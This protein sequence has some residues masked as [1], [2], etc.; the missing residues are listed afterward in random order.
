MYI[1][2]YLV[3][4]TKKNPFNGDYCNCNNNLLY[5]LK[6]T[7]HIINMYNVYIKK[8]TINYSNWTIFSY[9]KSLFYINF[10]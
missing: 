5:E 1:I 2:H 6:C 10:S 4:S 3:L 7:Q 9:P 8:K